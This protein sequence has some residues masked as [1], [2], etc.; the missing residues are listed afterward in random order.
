MIKILKKIPGVSIIADSI[1]SFIVIIKYTL[2]INT[3]IEDER[4]DP[5]DL[6]G[7][8]IHGRK[9][10]SSAVTMRCPFQTVKEY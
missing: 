9:Y 6:N 1:S 10:L 7:M 4:A 5:D 3:F 2:G 8:T